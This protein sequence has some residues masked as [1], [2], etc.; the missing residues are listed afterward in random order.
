M[1]WSSSGR[2]L[3]R[4]A[5][6]PTPGPASSC[7]RS[8]PAASAAPTCTCSTAR[9]RSTSR[10]ASSATR[11]SARRPTDR[12][13]AC[14]GSAGRAATCAYCAS[15]RENLCPQRALHRPRHRRRLRR[16]RGRRR[17]LLLRDPG[18][19]PRPAGR[20]AAVRR[21]D[22]LPRAALHAATRRGSA[23]TASAP[24]RTSS[25]RSPSTR[26]GA[27]SRSRAAAHELRARARRGVGRRPGAPPEP[28]DAAIVF[29][30][31]GELVADARCEH[32]APGGT[33]VLRRHPHERH[34]EPSRTSCCG[35]SGR[36]RSVAN[37]T[38]ADGEE[39][40][41]LAPQRPGQDARDR[42]TR[43]SR[44][45]TGARRPPRRRF[46]GAAVVTP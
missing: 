19:L 4:R 38:R 1:R 20:A 8:T 35:A 17:A 30:P 22:R 33:V 14:R 9:S 27:C 45:A 25:P 10:R 42:A 37:L 39:F 5:A 32:L 15:G 41:A 29:A 40:L 23:C 2:R 44:R 7:S 28:L 31:A 43:S 6:V 12:A 46:T 36:I 16:V 24:R 21:A 11:S 34:P 18:R 13:S 26:A 3:R